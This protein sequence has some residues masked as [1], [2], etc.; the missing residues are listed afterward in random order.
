VAISDERAL[1]N[2]RLFRTA[3]ERIHDRR[4]ELA[5]DGRT[6]Y[7]CECE[8]PGC[9]QLIR[10]T[11]DEYADIRSS[12]GQFVIV[13]GHTTRGTPVEETDRYVVVSKE[14]G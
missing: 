13:S 12:R 2:E 8:E 3:N 14:H 9:T 10:L 4:T 6:P 7:L 5:L 11:R 1:E